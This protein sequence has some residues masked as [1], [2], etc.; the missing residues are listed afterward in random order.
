MNT[1]LPENHQIEKEINTSID[2]FFKQ[3][4]LGKLLKQSNFHKQAGFSCTYILR[5]IFMLV[6]TGKNMFWLLHSGKTPDGP[7]KDA[8]YRFLNS[9][10]YNWRKFLLLLSS[11]VI[12]NHITPLTSDDRVNVLILDDSLYSR[13]RSK[14]VELLA[15]VYDHV[16]HKYHR[17]FRMLTL[18]WSDGNTF[19]PIKFGKGTESY[20]RYQRRH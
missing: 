13:N 1:I 11:A 5:F 16:S 14:K 12:N 18:G 10:H 17:G 4:G 6:F 9:A 15:K 2:T 20:L 3:N 8:V 7:A 19:L